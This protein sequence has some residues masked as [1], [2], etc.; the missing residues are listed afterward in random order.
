MP[1]PHELLGVA[2]V[3]QQV[4][5][6]TTDDDAVGAGWGCTAVACTHIPGGHRC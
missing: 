5:V 2:D 3:E 1:P 4:L 6:L